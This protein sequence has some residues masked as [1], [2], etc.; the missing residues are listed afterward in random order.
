MR[1]EIGIESYF[2]PAGAFLAGARVDEANGDDSTE[3]EDVH[4]KMHLCGDAGRA[5]VAE[6]IP[7]GLLDKLRARQGRGSAEL[8]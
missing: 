5:L 6:D 3:R 1:I 7:G 4:A 8:H 2:G